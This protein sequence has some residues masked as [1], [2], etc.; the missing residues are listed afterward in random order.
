ME[1]KI[2]KE[3]RDYNDSIVIGLSARQFG[4]TLASACV[5]LGL[6]F[7][8]KDTL[9]TNIVQWICIIAVLP[10]AAMGFIQY[11]GMPFEKIV[12][13]MV[14]TYITTPTHLCFHSKNTYYAND[15]EQKIKLLAKEEA[16]RSD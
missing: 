5:A 2:N 7:L 15:T 16:K 9:S 4:F 1:V 3:I 12:M 13:S 11:N 14:T 8:L 6:Y 10:L